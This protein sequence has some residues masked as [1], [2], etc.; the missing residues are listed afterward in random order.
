MWRSSTRMD[1]DE[2]STSGSTTSA[3]RQRAERRRR[4]ARRGKE[5]VNAAED[6]EQ[7]DQVPPAEEEAP[8]AED[9]A[10]PSKPAVKVS[11][12]GAASA[13]P[14]SPS[15]AP[16]VTMGVADNYD[17]M[18][19]AEKRCFEAYITSQMDNSLVNYACR[20]T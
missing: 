14:E 1:F 8:P 20:L 6:E 5:R 15:P 10:S 2:D 7:E 3:S 16:A 17:K 19:D 9:E 11:S 13:V 18:D 12:V 4:A